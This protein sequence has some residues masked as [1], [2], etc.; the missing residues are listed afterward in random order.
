MMNRLKNR[1]PGAGGYREVL[2]LAFPL[3]LSTGSMTIQHFVDRIFLTW[4]SPEA[5]AAAM[6]A[7]MISFTFMSLFIGTA[8]YVNTFVAQY[9][10]AK[11]NDR[12]GPA[13]WQGIYFSLIGALCILPLYFLAPVCLH[14]QD[15]IR[16]CKS[17]N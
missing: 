9:F 16:L 14:L 7:A 6:P 15:M 11:R 17:W 1:W 12:I 3:I 13:V 10:G 5:I 2:K 8:T 4:Y